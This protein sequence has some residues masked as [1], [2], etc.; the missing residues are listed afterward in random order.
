MATY[1]TF[2]AAPTSLTNVGTLATYTFA[3]HGFL[4]NAKVVIS[5]A[6][7]SQYN[8]TFN[9]DDTKKKADSLRPAIWDLK[10]KLNTPI[11]GWHGCGTWWYLHVIMF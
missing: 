6:A 4:D 2:I 3:N 8:G 11:K 1:S 9:I 10:E 7:Y 5:G